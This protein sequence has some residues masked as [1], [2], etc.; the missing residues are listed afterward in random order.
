MSVPEQLAGQAANATEEP[1]AGHARASPSFAVCV[2]V[3]TLPLILSL[4][5]F[6]AQLAES[7]L[8]DW[9]KQ[10]LVDRTIVSGWSAVHVPSLLEWCKFLGH[11]TMAL[12]LPAGLAFYLLGLRRGMSAARLA[13]IAALAAASK[14]STS[15]VGS[16]SA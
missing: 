10:P 13:K 9:M 6:S 12:L 4:A 1:A 3:V 15:A 11:P 2:L 14:P 8:P 16:A 7:H 5:G